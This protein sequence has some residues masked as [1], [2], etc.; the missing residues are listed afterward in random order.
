MEAVTLLPGDELTSISLNE[1]E[2][3]GGGGAAGVN[4]IVSNV[5]LENQNQFKWNVNKKFNSNPLKN[6]IYRQIWAENN[7][8]RL[9]T[10][11]RLRNL[12]NTV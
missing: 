9:E 5:Q 1:D 8:K 4:A 10:I 11:L 12:K 2:G 7:K 3:G 6:I